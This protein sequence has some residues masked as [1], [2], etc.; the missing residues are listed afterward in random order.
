[1]FHSEDFNEG[2]LLEEVIRSYTNRRIY[3]NFHLSLL[4][5]L[6]LPMDIVRMLYTISDDENSKKNVML[7][8]IEAMSKM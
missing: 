8:D 1:M 5:F 3:D 4:D 2:S 7:K 6:S